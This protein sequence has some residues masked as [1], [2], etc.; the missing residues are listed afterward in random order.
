MPVRMS[1]PQFQQS[2]LRGR[3]EAVYCFDGEEP[4][5]HDEAVRLLERAVLAEGSA[6]VDRDLVHGDEATL[7][8]VLDIA[9]TYP[10]GGG[11]RLVVVRDAD[12]V[13]LQSADPLERYLDRPNP[14]TCL[15]FSDLRFDRRRAMWRA[16][17]RGATLV[18]CA[19]PGEARMPGWVRERL[20]ARG[21]GVTAD[22]AEAIAAGFQGQ[23]LGRLDS[24]LQKLMSAIGP[25][26]PVRP[27]D[28]EILAG[29]PRVGDVWAAARQMVRGRGGEAVAAVRGL[30]RQG[31]D[32]LPLLGALSWYV[33]MALKAR[34]A[35]GRR[36]PPRE[37]QSTYGIDPGRVER[38]RAE[39]GDVPVGR[40]R[41][42]LA[43]CLR[44]DRELKGA[45]S[46]DP[47]HALERLIHRVARG[48]TRPA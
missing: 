19:P 14:K 33:R 11:R 1:F 17:Q 6:A 16:L 20:Q 37:L 39:V 23:G 30:L 34:S 31:E 40:L 7:E 38:M 45:G 41:E 44:A 28:L 25:P 18:E 9:A 47:A 48:A 26:R 27:E 13:R 42:A 22:L 29:V 2:L 10:M 4:F 46:R 43:L 32:P 35:A 8:M 24:E 12:A 21:Y 36:I 5:L 15:M 3:V